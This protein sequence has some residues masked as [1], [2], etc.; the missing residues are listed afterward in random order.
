MELTDQLDLALD[1]HLLWRERLAQSVR[2]R[3]SDVAVEL[4]ADDSCCNFG[5]WLRHL[6][7][8]EKSNPQWREA[9]QLHVEFHQ[10]AAA[11]L[12]L[13]LQG[14]AAGAEQ[15][16]AEGGTFTQASDKLGSSL[17]RWRATIGR[18]PGQKQAPPADAGPIRQRD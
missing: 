11:V 17:R 4:V 3:A 6:P 2:T 7:G 12:T 10:E 1:A 9:H 5:L 18:A 15:R 13:A 8:E 16:L 14:E